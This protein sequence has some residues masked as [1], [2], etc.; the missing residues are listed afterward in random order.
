MKDNKQSELKIFKSLTHTLESG[1]TFKSYR[2][3]CK[4]FGITDTG[5]RAKTAII[6]ELTKCCEWKKEGNSI[7]IIKIKP[8]DLQPQEIDKKYL[9]SAFY[10]ECSYLLLVFLADEYSNNAE[11]IAYYT[12]KRRL[13]NIMFMC[14]SSYSEYSSDL[15]DKISSRNPESNAFIKEAGTYL[16]KITDRTIDW[17][18]ERG[19]INYEE[20]YMVAIK[21][22]KLRKN[23]LREATIEET[24]NINT[25][26]KVIKDKYD[27]DKRTIRISPRKNEI[28]KEIKNN[29]GY[30]HYT[31]IKFYL[32]D[33]LENNADYLKRSANLTANCGNKVNKLMY[34]NIYNLVLKFIY[35]IRRY[36]NMT[37]E[38]FIDDFVKKGAPITNKNGKNPFAKTWNFNLDDNVVESTIE[39]LVSSY[40]R[41]D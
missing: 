40:I 11:N 29:L 32:T 36:E 26:Y 18:K 14:N 16:S 25:Y 28:D 24:N 38:E 6:A 13:M 3:L 5:G 4:Y 1:M 15:I 34:D 27:L 41:I 17:L 21:D 22:N 2:H 30:A 12:T 39:G 20:V 9:K 8:D 31:A 35:K 19:L 37:F 7:S 33:E 23:K 10:P